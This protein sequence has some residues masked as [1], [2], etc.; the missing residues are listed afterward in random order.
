LRKMCSMRTPHE[1]AH[2]FFSTSMRPEYA[3][4]IFETDEEVVAYAK[5]D[6]LGFQIYYLWGGSRRRF[7]PDFLVRLAN[8]KTLA[9]EIKGEDS[10]QNK[11]KRDALGEWVAA[12]N[13]EGG[14]G[15]WAWDVAFEPAKIRDIVD[16]HLQKR[17]ASRPRRGIVAKKPTARTLSG[18]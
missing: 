15:P 5:N 11:A 17:N 7:I 2:I 10:P 14:F 4:N 18:Q 6:H 1:S 9:L 12:V 16:L 13:G 8:G 3:A